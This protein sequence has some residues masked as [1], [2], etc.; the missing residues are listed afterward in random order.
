MVG[1]SAHPVMPKALEQ[2]GKNRFTLLRVIL[3][4]L[5]EPAM[6]IKG[7]WN[8]VAGCHREYKYGAQI[9]GH[10]GKAGEGENLP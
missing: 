9:P 3:E 4:V 6:G 1:H 10:D 7:T 2:F 5:P 8:Q